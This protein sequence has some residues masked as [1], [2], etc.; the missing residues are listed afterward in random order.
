MDEHVRHSTAQVSSD[1]RLHYVTANPGNP[2]AHTVLLIHGYP[3]TWF[4]WRH[5]IEPL[6]TAGYHVVAP[7]YRG[8]GDSNKPPHGGFDKMSMAKELHTL[9][10]EVLKITEPITVV[11]HDIGGMVAFAYAA[12]YPD[13][14]RGLI[15]GECPLPGTQV[16]EDMKKSEGMWHFTFHNVPHLP[17]T[18]TYGREGIYIRHFYERLCSDPSFLKDSD[19][20]HYVKSFERAGA[21]RCGFELYRA[22]EQDATDNRNHLSS[23]GK[24][25]MPVLGLVGERGPFSTVTSL[26]IEEV[27]EVP[28]VEM[29]DGAGHWCAEERPEATWQAIHQ[30][31]KTYQMA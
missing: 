9:I 19:L 30:F 13:Q 1:S 16:Y 26:M 28:K 4:Q 3:Q 24:L 20:D 2:E 22:F 6:R 12:L 14:T 29:L 31:I 18:L 17:E 21:M 7:D 15:F 25:K 11:G 27:A 23:K 5:V 8:A 10:T